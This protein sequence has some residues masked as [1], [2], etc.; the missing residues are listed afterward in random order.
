MFR[1]AVFMLIL[2]AALLLAAC[3]GS[4]N[5]VQNSLSSGG[6]GG[7]PAQEQSVPMPSLTATPMA[8][9]VASA[10]GAPA[11]RSG[12][13]GEL[14]TG[15]DS[16]PQPGQR[17][18][19][20]NATIRIM[21]EDPA[22][23][24]A[25]IIAMAEE[26]GGWVVTSG[27]STSTG[28]GGIT[29]VRGNITV[30]VPADRL[31]DALDQIRGYAIQVEAENIS[32]QDV[33]QDYVDTASRLANLLVTE[34]QLQSIMA[35]ATTVEDVLAV[36]SELTRVRGDIEVLQGRL[37]YFNEAAAY[38]SIQVQINPPPADPITTQSAGWDPGQTASGALGFVVGALQFL[39]DVLI[40]FVIICL[41]PL[42]VMGLVGW[43]GWRGFRARRSRTAAAG[44]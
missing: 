37:N 11:V 21:A 18:I 26:M 19:L 25:D 23:V 4:F 3:G 5:N 28:S 30:R 20:R 12:D 6:S 44:S 29:V 14:S 13:A 35:T 27:T 9:V 39:A 32:G 7:V 36:Q 41:P 10:P 34:E 24:V 38:S 17:V 16:L 31:N 40:S 2:V 43:L 22:A 1:S 33:T 42:L 8:L 15:D